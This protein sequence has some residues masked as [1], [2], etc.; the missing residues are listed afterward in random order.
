MVTVTELNRAPN[1]RFD[2]LEAD[3]LIGAD[4][5]NASADTV[6]ISQGDGTLS[7]GAVNVSYPEVQTY[8]DL[9]LPAPER[10]TYYVR[11]A[12]DAVF[13]SNADL[14]IWRSLSDYTIVALEIPDSGVARWQF[15]QD[16]TDSW[17]GND[18]TD[19]T[20]AGYSTNAQEGSHSKAFDRS[21]DSVDLSDGSAFV[22]DSFSVR[23][24]L[25]PTW[26]G[27]S[28]GYAPCFFALRS[29]SDVR[30]SIHVTS[31]TGNYDQLVIYNGGASAKPSVSQLA[32]DTWTDVVLTYNSGSWT[33]YENGSESST[34][35]K[36][37]SGTE[38]LHIGSS[39]GSQ[40]YWGGNIDDSRFYSK[41]LTATEVSNLHQTG[42]ID[43]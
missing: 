24:W 39:T 34:A 43:G 21:D 10:R 18:L 9:P 23:A 14:D 31:G 35:S 30:V 19:N 6:P 41:E 27:G 32:Q 37:V 29:G 2:T 20:S 36:S 25:Y 13:P 17:N 22:F 38:P 15:E 12:Q 5:Q 26:S 28:I 11:D 33:V 7:M 3:T 42:S 4:V 16:V 1:G 8:D 40:E